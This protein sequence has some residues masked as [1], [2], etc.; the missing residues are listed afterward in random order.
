[1]VFQIAKEVENVWS[2]L[3]IL[4]VAGYP[5]ISFF[6]SALFPEITFIRNTVIG[7]RAS[8]SIVLWEVITQQSGTVYLDIGSNSTSSGLIAKYDPLVSNIEQFV[9]LFFTVAPFWMFSS[10]SD[11]YQY[12]FIKEPDVASNIQ[13]VAAINVSAILF[14]YGFALLVMVT[15]FSNFVFHFAYV[16]GFLLRRVRVKPGFRKVLD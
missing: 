10:P 14:D 13:N 3:K 2:V 8:H 7:G 15:E 1:M 6:E 11:F 16:C 12:G 5:F 4:M 9:A